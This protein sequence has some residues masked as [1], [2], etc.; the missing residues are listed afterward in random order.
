MPHANARAAIVI[1]VT[2]C[3][4]VLV[5]VGAFL[6]LLWWRDRS[7]RHRGESAKEEARRSDDESARLSH[8]RDALRSLRASGNPV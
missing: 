4:G 3:V 5:M 1:A 6:E 7:L 2:G 8:L